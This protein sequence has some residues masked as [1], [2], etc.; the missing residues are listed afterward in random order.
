M[1]GWF[2]KKKKTGSIEVEQEVVNEETIEEVEIVEEAEET[3]IKE[4]V[5]EEPKKR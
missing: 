4:N 3:E 2:K 5:Q 1:F